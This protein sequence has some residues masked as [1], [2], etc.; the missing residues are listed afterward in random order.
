MTGHKGLIGE[1]LLRKLLERGDEP[2]ALI[3]LREGKDILDIHNLGIEGKADVLIHLAALCKIN[4]SISNPEETFRHNVLGTHH[5]LEFCRRNKIP[6]VIF[7]SSTRVL[8]PE[9]NP[10]TASKVFG[11]EL[12]KAYNHS[13]GIEYV[14]V[15]PST[16]YGPFN[17]HTRRLVD[18]FIMNALEGKPLE[19]Y[20]DEEKTLD[21]TYVEDFV[22]GFL[23]AMEQKNEEFDISYGEPVKIVDVAKHIIELNGGKGEYIHLSPEI[24]QPQRVYIDISKIKKLGFNPKVHVKEGIKRTFE[25]Y[26]QNYEIIKKSRGEILNTLQ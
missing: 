2:V 9:K 17:D 20:G 6:K 1:F 12:V 24:A 19:I 13:Y 7:T 16:V 11:E 10:Y 15:R 23:L 18:I 26:K 8:H 25:W 21:F 14:I 4:K 3:D 22:E 5:V